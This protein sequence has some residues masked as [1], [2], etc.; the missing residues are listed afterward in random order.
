MEIRMIK[1]LFRKSLHKLGYEVHR[2][3]PEPIRKEPG[4]PSDLKFTQQVFLEW[5]AER[6]NISIDESRARYFDSWSVFR[7]GHGGRE[8]RDW[9]LLCNRVLQVFYGDSEKETFDSYRFYGAIHFLRFLSYPETR[10]D[11][12]NDISQYLIGYPE[13]TIL[14]FGCGMAQGSRG[15]AQY[16]SGKNVKVRL[17]LADIPTIRKEFLIWLGKRTGIPTTFLDCT[18]ERP[19]PGLPE[20]DVCFVTEFFEHVHDPLKY[21]EQIHRALCRDALLITDLSYH[22]KEFMHVSPILEPLRNR[23]L[24]LGY[25][26]VRPNTLYK[27]KDNKPWIS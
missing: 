6:L 14:D 13:V 8:F 23:V 16:L 2:L 7:E 9:D 22:H 18:E 21:L 15:L 4:P 1:S 17:F 20:C 26:E 5:N 25:E 11:Q 12:N 3:Q 10:C 19:I 24:T 27:K